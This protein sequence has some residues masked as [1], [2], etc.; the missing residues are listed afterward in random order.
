MKLF[1]GTSGRLYEFEALISDDGKQGIIFQ[2]RS[3]IGSDLYALKWYRPSMATMNQRMQLETL[4]ERGAPQIQLNNISFIWPLEMVGQQESTRF[5]YIMPLV[6]RSQYVFLNEV[7]YGHIKQPNPRNLAR[8]SYLLCVALD[9]IHADG[10][11]YCDISDDNIAFDIQNVRIIIWDNDNVVVDNTDVAVKGT[12]DFMAPEVWFDES[13][14]NAEA[15]LYSVAVLL[16]KMWM[17]E[18]P[19]DGENTLSLDIWDEPAIEEYYLRKPVFAFHPTDKSNSAYRADD[20]ELS[21]RRWEKQCP[22]TLKDAFLQSFT[23]GVHNPSERIRLGDWRQLFLSLEANAYPC[24]KC[25]AFNL[26]DYTVSRLRCF[27]CETVLPLSLVLHNHQQGNEA[28]LV[29]HNGAL[30]RGHHLGLVDSI[31]EADKVFGVVE[32][33]P[34]VP[35]FHIL[36]NRTQDT[37]IYDT[38]KGQFQIEPGVARALLPDSQLSIGSNTI[39]IER[40]TK[41]DKK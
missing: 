30:L 1:E 36:R 21:V 34:N 7:T 40:L 26:V 15:D 4:I 16:Y 19:M 27:H 18:H 13:K 33:H 39:I 11:A 22:H 31:T 20:L 32:E 8:L 38:S 28:Q 41:S 12:L 23:A 9:A 17:W 14:P 37:W 25:T 2:V 5:G 10:F 35:G 6:D 3:K 24:P 29:V